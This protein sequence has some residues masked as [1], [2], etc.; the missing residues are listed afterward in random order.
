[1]EG[2]RQGALVSKLAFKEGAF[3]SSPVKTWYLV[4]SALKN[5]KWDF[6]IFVDDFGGL[7]FVGCGTGG[8][9]SGVP[10]ESPRQSYCQKRQTH[11]HTLIFSVVLLRVCR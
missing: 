8:F 7:F 10:L 11:M 9:C 6:P 4:A 1:M 5:R 3:G 2:S